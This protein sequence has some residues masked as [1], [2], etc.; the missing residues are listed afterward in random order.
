MSLLQTPFGFHSTA[1]EVLQRVDLSGR[2]A[3][4]TGGA[5]GIGLETARALVN[6]G[7]GVTLAVRR[8]DAVQA[9]AEELRAAGRG[10]V[11]VAALDLADLGSVRDFAA[12]WRGPLHMLINNAGVMALPELQTTAQG[13]ELQLATNFLG[14]FALVQGLHPAL[15]AA[16]GARIV[17]VSSSAHLLGPVVF[18]DLHFAFR[19]YDPLVAYAQAKT[20]CVLLAVEATRRWHQEGIFANALHPGAIATRLQQYTGGL[21]TPLDRRKTPE[22]GAATSVLLAASPL[23]TGIGGRFFEDCNEAALVQRRPDDYTGVAPYA[24]DPANA[25][26]LWEL[27]SEVALRTRHAAQRRRTVQ[28]LRSSE[29]HLR[30]L[31]ASLDQQVQERT[32]QLLASE[33]ALHQS[34]KMEAVG[35]LAGGLAHD[36]NNLLGA[37]SGSLELLKRRIGGDSLALRHVDIGQ[38]AVRRAAM[39]T[40]R[41]LAFSRKQALEARVVDVN[42]LIAGFEE[43]VRRTLGPQIA[44]EVRAAP[45]PWH[46]CADAGQLENALLNLCINARDAMPSG[47][48]LVV[49]TGN[50][51]LDAQEAGLQ[52]LSAGEFV[53]ITVQESGCGMSSD[54]V[55]KAFDPF[56]TTESIGAGSG[57]GLPMVYGFARQSGGQVHIESQP[58]VG[59]KVSMLLPR[60]DGDATPEPVMELPA[61]ATD[62]A[63]H[64]RTVLVG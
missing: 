12:R 46:V 38:S 29:A 34:Q 3:V 25:R 49:F 20:A 22:Q 21:K 13:W 11:Q 39:L 64:G 56:F 17:C 44:L 45:A 43:P 35:Q 27:A 61:L 57:L 16:D 23:L 1:R 37:I 60:C 36:F 52:A 63:G 59:T 58:G 26:R 9:V 31:S 33:A 15:P 5:S 28:R 47:G 7:A 8:P 50:R 42:A 51:L 55:A 18:D 32:A 53:V 40:H 24:V 19:G 6:A 62:R 41:L 54:V 30:Q 4:V 2:R 14:H 10:A 48:R